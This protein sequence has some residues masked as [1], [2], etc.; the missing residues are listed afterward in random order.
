MTCLRKAPDAARLVGPEGENGVCSW[1]SRTAS[2]FSR[3]P[4]L[5]TTAGAMSRFCSRDHCAPAGCSSTSA[6]PI[7]RKDDRQTPPNSSP[8]AI[9]RQTWRATNATGGMTAALALGAWF[10]RHGSGRNTHIP[11]GLPLAARTARNS[12]S[13]SGTKSDVR[14]P[15][16]VGIRDSRS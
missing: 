4:K 8:R 6:S 2:Q 7:H 3:K 14:A 9:P 13:N 10:S 12:R 11:A 5:K 15:D 16:T 1:L